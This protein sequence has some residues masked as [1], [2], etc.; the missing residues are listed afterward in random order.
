MSKEKTIP[1]PQTIRYNY[2]DDETD[3]I[4]FTHLEETIYF[5]GNLAV[6][7]KPTS[8]D[9]SEEAVIS[10]NIV[11]F[12]NNPKLFVLDVNSTLVR[13]VAKQLVEQNM[14]KPVDR[15]PVR[16]GFVTYPVYELLV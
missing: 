13:T 11:R 1:L 5:D 15:P 12:P 9:P 10:V 16:S 2:F 7:L 4:E 8:P 3:F 14:I 6:V